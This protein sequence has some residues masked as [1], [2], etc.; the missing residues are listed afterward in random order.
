[1]NTCRIALLP[2]AM[3]RLARTA[4]PLG[5]QT[6]LF[7]AAS[8]PGASAA[9]PERRDAK[10]VAPFRS[11]LDSGSSSAADDDVTVT[12]AT[13]HSNDD[14]GAADLG[15]PAETVVELRA[16]AREAGGEGAIRLLRG[17][18]SEE[19]NGSPTRGGNGC[20]G[21]NGYR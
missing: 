16:Y 13:E 20:F 1:M 2:I 14:F 4:E 10:L 5:L 9:L 8:I 18:Y 6:A 3:T 19:P 21:P 15:I 12:A 7:A 17:A 11:N